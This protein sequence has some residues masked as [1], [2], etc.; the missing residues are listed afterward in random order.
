MASLEAL[1]DRHQAL[2]QAMQERP[3]N[4]LLPQVNAFVGEIASAGKAITDARS[5]SRLRSVL[6]FWASY[7]YDCTGAFPDVELLH[8]EGEPATPPEGTEQVPT[9]SGRRQIGPYL[10][11]K[12]IGSGGFSKVFQALHTGT[13]QVVALKILQSEQFDLLPQLRDRLLDRERLVRDLDHPRIIPVYS[14][15]DYDGVAC[16]AMKYVESGSLADRLSGWYWP[17]SYR[18]I[19][20]IVLQAAEGLDYLHRLGIVH[21]DIKP[22]NLLLSYDHQVL[23]TDFGIAQFLEQAFQGMIVGTPEYIAPEAIISP[24]SV[25]GRADIYG[26]GCLLFE[27]ITGNP[28]FVGESQQ[29]LLNKQVNLAPPPITSVPFELAQLVADC[30]KKQPGE[31]IASATALIERLNHL[32]KVLPEAFLD[33]VPIH[34]QSAPDRRYAAIDSKPITQIAVLPSGSVVRQEENQRDTHVCPVCGAPNP[35]DQRF[36]DQCGSTLREAPSSPSRAAPPPTPVPTR[37]PPPGKRTATSITAVLPPPLAATTPGDTKVP[38]TVLLQG[39]EGTEPEP[40]LLALFLLEG[41]RTVEESIFLVAGR[42]LLIGRERYC[43][44]IL[45]APTVSR[46]HALL[47]YHLRPDGRGEFTLIDLASASGTFVNGRRVKGRAVLPHNA[48][49]RLGGVQLLFKRLDDEPPPE[50]PLRM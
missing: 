47:V 9:S 37:S 29:E 19:I 38:A 17:A 27:L 16:I 33:S 3:E 35:P 2:L 10:L 8:P 31:R 21:R 45:S 22:A 41:D 48:W 23:L 15:T 43:D 11:L 18:T 14:V 40:L 13:Q 26:L 5:R 12:D 34:F 39:G 44:I 28:P 6:R 36:C 4:G 24:A 32:F 25:D 20:D 1:I 46:Q 30:L 50:P 42:R 49:V 7:I